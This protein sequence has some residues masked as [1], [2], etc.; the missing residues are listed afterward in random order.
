MLINNRN[1]LLWSACMCIRSMLMR[2]KIEYPFKT[3][4]HVT[5]IEELRNHKNKQALKPLYIVFCC[6]ISEMRII[7]QK[8]FVSINCNK[9]VRSSMDIKLCGFLVP[10]LLLHAWVVTING[11]SDLLV[12]IN[13]RIVFLRLYNADAVK[14]NTIY[15]SN[16][17]LPDIK[18]YSITLLFLFLKF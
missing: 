2:H 18:V 15:W 16:I 5:T 9:P 10:Q 11:Q 17:H 3:C 12:N 7:F 1:K 8:V 4:M 14:P 6:F 13:D